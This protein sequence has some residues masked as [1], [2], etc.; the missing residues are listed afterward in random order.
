MRYGAPTSERIW[1][2]NRYEG[3]GKWSRKIDSNTCL[4]LVYNR[5]K[6]SGK[7]IDYI[8]NIVEQIT[9]HLT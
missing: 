2:E 4:N 7:G 5:Y 9:N 6:I 8:R 3:W 1:N